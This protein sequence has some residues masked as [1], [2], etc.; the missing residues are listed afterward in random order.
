MFSRKRNDEREI[1]ST[2]SQTTLF[3]AIGNESKRRQGS[4][5]LNHGNWRWIKEKE[6]NT[7]TESSTVP[8]PFHESVKESNASQLASQMIL[9][10]IHE[11][12]RSRRIS[13]FQP[14]M[15]RSWKLRNTFISNTPFYGTRY[16][17]NTVIRYRY[18][19]IPSSSTVIRYRIGTGSI[20]YRTRTPL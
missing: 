15:N 16:R 3:P 5:C 4:Q 6:M 19:P 9:Q 18:L 11:S 12:C 2:K 10:G 7:I 13:N 8:R 14:T 17:E 20:Q 1:S